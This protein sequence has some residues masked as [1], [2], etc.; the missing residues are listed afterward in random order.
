MA[1]DPDTAKASA[2]IPEAARR[3]GRAQT[4]TPAFAGVFAFPMDCRVKPGND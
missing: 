1:C 3:T 2:E 4:K